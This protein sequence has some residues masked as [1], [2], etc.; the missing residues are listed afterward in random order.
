VLTG[1]VHVEAQ[2]LHSC[3]Y[4]IVNTQLLFSDYGIFHGRNVIGSEYLVVRVERS[5]KLYHPFLITPLFLW[6]IEARVKI[7]FFAVFQDLVCE[8]LT[9][10]LTQTILNMELT[11]LWH[12]NMSVE[13]SA[14]VI[15][16]DKDITFEWET[17]ILSE[18]EVIHL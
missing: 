1:F 11:E 8:Y 10:W 17:V 2:V 9:Y 5:H 13:N 16:S 15:L 4:I 3:M 7:L 18:Q 14:E 12:M 6:Y